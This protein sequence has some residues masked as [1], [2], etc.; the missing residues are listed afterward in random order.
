MLTLFY[1]SEKNAPLRA[2]L[3][4]ALKFYKENRELLLALSPSG[5][6]PEAPPKKECPKAETEGESFKPQEDLK[7]IEEF[8]KR[9]K[10]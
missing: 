3:E 4:K 5:G 9:Q 8:L 10:I 1:L 6:A 2:A 7:L